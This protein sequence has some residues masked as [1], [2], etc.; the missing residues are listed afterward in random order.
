MGSEDVKRQSPN[1]YR[2]K[3]LGATVVPVESGSK[4]LKG[5][6][7][8]SH[9]RLGRQRGQHLLHHRHRGGPAPLPDDGARLPERDRQ[10]MPGA[11][12]RHAGQKRKVNRAA[13]RRGGLR[14]RRQ[15]RHGHLLPLHQRSVPPRLI[16]VEAAGKAWTA[17]SI[18][19][20]SSAA[21]RRAA[22]QPH[23][24]AAGRQRPGHRDAQR[25]R[26]PGLSR[27]GPRA[28]LH[29][30]DI[31]RAEYVG[32]TDQEALDA[33]TTCAAPKASSR[34]WNPATPWPTA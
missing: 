29:L 1:V 5:R 21:A 2:M 24:R 22:R 28:R 25:E 18:R 3:L 17:A 16:G 15:Q 11:D 7:E 32:I 27:R 14:G 33:F 4:T 30:A 13:R 31:G 26:G 8:R 34:R 23:L 19:R 9:A 6:P 10:G 12:A 20:P